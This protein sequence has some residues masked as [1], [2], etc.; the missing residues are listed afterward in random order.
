MIAKLFAALAIAVAL[1]GTAAAHHKPGHHIPPGQMK[2]MYD[3]RVVVPAE[4]EFVCLVTTEIAGDPYSSVVYSEWLPRAD[5]EA[6]ADLGQS[7]IIYH[8][9][10]NTEAGCADF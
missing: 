3:Q 1:T 6:K 7:F 9:D 10:L 5:A 8:P 2:K 4:A